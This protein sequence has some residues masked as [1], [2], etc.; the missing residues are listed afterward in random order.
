MARSLDNEEE[1]NLTVILLDY[2]LLAFLF[3][4]TVSLCGE[5]RKDF[6]LHCHCLWSKV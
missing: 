5:R 1:I 2:I 3:L 6:K 4:V